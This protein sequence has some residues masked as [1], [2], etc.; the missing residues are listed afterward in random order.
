MEVLQVTHHDDHTAEVVVKLDA[1]AFNK[2]LRQAARRAAKDYRI[3]GFRPGKAPY[4]VVE[5]MIGRQALVSDVLDDVGDEMF[6]FGLEET[7]IELYAPGEIT[8]IQDTE[9]GLSLAFTVAKMPEA[10]LGNYRDIRLDFEVPEVS[11]SDVERYMERLYQAQA[12]SELADRPA[13]FGDKAVLNIHSFFV[14]EENE[15]AADTSEAEATDPHD[16]EREVYIH[17]HNLETILY[18]DEALDTIMPGFA[19]EIVGLEAGSEKS[20]RLTFPS[21]GDV[22]ESFQGRTV[23]FNIE[24]GKVKSRILPPRDDFFAVLATDNETKTLEELTELVRDILENDA[25]E[26]AESDYLEEVIDQIVADAE[27]DYPPQMVEAHL[28]SMME[29]L[30]QQLQQEVGMK[31]EDFLRMQNIN[32]EELRDQRRPQAIK[33]LR[34]TLILQEVAAQEDLYLDDAEVEAKITQQIMEQFGEGAVMLKDFFLRDEAQRREWSTRFLNERLQKRLMDIAKGLEPPIGP[35]PEPEVDE[36]EETE[37]EEA[38]T[39]ADSTEET[40]MAAAVDDDVEDE[41]EDTE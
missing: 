11:E 27:V 21:D 8:D 37:A 41:V 25:Q 4:N 22:L 36:V 6:R 10:T 7:G 40:V 15:D 19:A 35:D 32:E 28:D 12:L 18:E 30:D 24:V 38:V 39:E 20:F 2:A 34:T 31:L 5:N 14:D 13:A 16:D 9:D 1:E 23:D 26:K 3:P 17:E 33:S 29:D